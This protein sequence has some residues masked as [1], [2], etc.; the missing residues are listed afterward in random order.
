MIKTAHIFKSSKV[1]KTKLDNSKNLKLI[2]PWNDIA[3]LIRF[4]FITADWLSLW[5]IKS[6]QNELGCVCEI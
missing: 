2:L 1:M 5:A 6:G 4:D 3:D